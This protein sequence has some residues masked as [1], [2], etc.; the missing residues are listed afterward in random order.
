MPKRNQKKRLLE[1]A[2]K[3]LAKALREEREALV[4]IAI[5]FVREA[6]EPRAMRRR[7]EAMA[8]SAEQDPKLPERTRAMMRTGVRLVSRALEVEARRPQGL[9]DPNVGHVRPDRV[10]SLAGARTDQL[11]IGGGDGSIV[12]VEESAQQRQAYSSGAKRAIL[13]CYRT[14]GGSLSDEELV[15]AYFER[16]IARDVPL[17]TKGRIKAYR[18]ELTRVGLLATDGPGKHNLIERVAQEGRKSA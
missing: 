11:G 17:L 18:I 13:D 15:H 5:A 9:F 16:A 10:R 6:N 1:A 14:A 2:N 4:A 7:L 12:D 8:R 3:G